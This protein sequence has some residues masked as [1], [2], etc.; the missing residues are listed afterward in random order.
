MAV[1][2]NSQLETIGL[3]PL[4][5]QEDEKPKFSDWPRKA[6]LHAAIKAQNQTDKPTVDEMWRI[7]KG[8]SVVS[9]VYCNM[10]IHIIKIQAVVTGGGVGGTDKPLPDE[11]YL[12]K[13]EMGVWT[14]KYLTTSEG[15]HK[16]NA[17]LKQAS[18]KDNYSVPDYNNYVPTQVMGAI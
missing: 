2:S 3:E 1:Y 4:R 11:F 10:G 13:E 18:Q 6:T 17:H 14:I 12:C 5:P 9:S 8:N 7:A 16:Q 15:P